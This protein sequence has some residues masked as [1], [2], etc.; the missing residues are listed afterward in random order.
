MS[1]SHVA[2]DPSI[3]K[4]YDVRGVYGETLNEGVAYRIG[5]AAAQQ[6][7]LTVVPGQFRVRVLN[8]CRVSTSEALDKTS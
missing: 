7:P 5:Q 4:A 6:F 2:V 8:V 1:T 3:F